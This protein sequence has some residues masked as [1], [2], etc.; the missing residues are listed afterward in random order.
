MRT[1]RQLV[2]IALTVACAG[3]QKYNPALFQGMRWR[4]IGPFRGGRVVA[5]AGVPSRPGLFY[6]GAVDG[7]VWKSDDYGTTWRPIFAGEDTGSIGALAVAPSNPDVIY[8][9]S[10]EGLHRPD[11]STGDGIYK[12]TDGGRT[13]THLGLRDAQQIGAIAVDPHD[14]NRLF[15][16][17][18]GHPYGPNTERG[19]YRSTDGG[20]SFTR[21]LYKD[22]NTGAIQV[23]LDPSDPNTVYADLWAARYT[24]WG[25][26]EGPGSGLYKSTDGGETWRPLT[27]GLPTWQSGHLGR[28]GI[29]I[30]PT[31][32]RRIYALVQA[33][34]GGGLYRSDDG[35]ENWRLVNDETRVYG[36]GDDFAGIVVDPR[37]EN[38]IY[39]ANTS[40]YRSTDAGQSFIP[41]KGAPGGDDYHSIWLDPANPLV[42]FLGVDQGAT[43]SVNGGRT[44]SSWYNQ[45]TAQFYHVAAD[46]HFP[47][48]VYGGQQESGSAGVLSRGD[49]GEITFRDWHPVGAEE[50]AM[51]AP[52]PLDPE[53]VYGG[54]VTRFDWRTHQAQNVAP[55]VLSGG[56]Y[57]F[58]RTAPLVFSPADPHALYLGSNVLFKTTDGGHSWTIVSP[59]LTRAQP[60]APPTLG[61]FAAAEPRQAQ[62][63]RGV[64]YSIAPSPL[65]AGLIWIGTDDGLIQVTRDGGKSW[66]NVT[67][68]ALAPWSKVA[69]IEASPFDRDEAYAAVNRFRAD[70]LRP[71]VYR[72]R[73]GG[74]TWQ[75]AARGLPDGAS[76]NVVRADPARR[77]LLYAGTETSVYVSF[78]DGDQWQSLQLNL[79]H[80]SMRDLTVHGD[81][82]IVGTHGR[83]FWILDDLT[84]LRQIRAAAAAHGAYLFAPETA[85]R[86]RRDTN[87]DTPLPP[88]VPAGENPPDGAILD[89]YLPAPASE[90]VTLAIYAGNGKVIRRYSSAERAPASIAE[91]N[92]TLRVPVYWVRPFR[93]LETGAGMHRFVWDLHYP[94]PDSLR[95]DYPIS[96][97]PHD[98]PLYPRGPA[99]LPGRYRVQ[100]SIA[101]HSFTQPLLVKMD[102]RVK[103]SAADLRQ[104][105]EIAMGV[106][107]ALNRDGAALRQAA[108]L[109]GAEASQIAGGLR[110]L[111][112]ELSALLAGGEQT[113]GIET[114]DRAP[115]VAQVAAARELQSQ[116]A[117]LLARLAALRPAH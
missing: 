101:G 75:P 16:A 1:F 91:L 64:I 6:F 32:P 71:Y 106:Y 74:G 68:P 112:G 56:K 76:V 59:D 18:L 70:D 43:I 82:L 15:V 39:A 34:P 21:V 48:R 114:V 72:T 115:T 11:L 52:D 109:S 66:R 13:W 3:A 94:P 61:P 93:P 87:T 62:P 85:W 103:T 12:S 113:G 86:V 4:L 89:Y 20:R 45:P 17:A 96:A 8:V 78:D 29:G 73:D 88:E 14:A 19:V 25:P 10:G 60:V 100:L 44:W 98:T 5:I 58:R 107:G 23:A 22:E 30:A 117:A 111:N 55:Q 63:A 36:R 9:G 28:I 84:P 51:V 102:P 2:L 42:I 24:P 38:T 105:F 57:R 83:S 67:P 92:A 50:Y 7:G 41:I 26:L 116:L 104:Q 46:N 65:D 69:T 35:G 53:I 99:V 97:I 27:Q 81:D 95:R 54:K 37:D 47:Y 40:T 77:G 90:T 49:D 110:R 31:D 80:T 79:P 108:A 33:R